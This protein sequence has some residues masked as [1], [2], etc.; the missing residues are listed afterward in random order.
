M[1]INDLS[2]FTSVPELMSLQGMAKLP[3]LS[4]AMTSLAFHVNSTI[5]RTSFAEKLTL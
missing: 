3:V 4:L 1:I 2:L 5:L